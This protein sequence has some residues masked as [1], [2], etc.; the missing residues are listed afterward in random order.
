MADMGLKY[1][2]KVASKG[3]EQGNVEILKDLHDPGREGTEEARKAHAYAT[4]SEIDPPVELMSDHHHRH[5][6]KLPKE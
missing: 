6:E 2:M 3:E 1:D 5:H 4:T